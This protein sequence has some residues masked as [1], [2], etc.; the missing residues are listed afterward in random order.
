M[1]QILLILIALIAVV[2]LV[3]K[4]ATRWSASMVSRIIDSRHR[5][6]EVIINDERVPDIWL[7]PF[8]NRIDKARRSGGRSDVIE[9]ISRS[10]QR[11]CLRRINSLINFFQKGGGFVSDPV[12]RETL[13]KSLGKQKDRWTSQEWKVLME[14]E[15]KS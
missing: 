4:L 15:A 8:R 9:K 12:I 6:A 10:G 11:Y 1:L 5:A 3:I 14:Q 2:L 7:Q 13:L